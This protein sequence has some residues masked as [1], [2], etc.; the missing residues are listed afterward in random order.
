MSWPQKAQ[1]RKTIRG[2]DPET[3]RNYYSDF[4]PSVRFVANPFV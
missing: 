2:T 4:A 1:N 3:S